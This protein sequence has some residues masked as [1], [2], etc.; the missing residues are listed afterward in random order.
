MNQQPDIV[1]YE[2]F[3]TP[4]AHCRQIRY[5]RNIF[6]NYPVRCVTTQFPNYLENIASEPNSDYLSSMFDSLFCE[7]MMCVPGYLQFSGP[8]AYIL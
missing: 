6:K 4:E 1:Y 8:F 5:R 7:Q 2:M 3:Y